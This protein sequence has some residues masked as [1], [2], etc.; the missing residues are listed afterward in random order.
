MPKNNKVDNC[1][2]VTMHGLNKWYQKESEHLGWMILAH[3]KG[4]DDKIT[5]YK[6]SL[7]L[8]KQSLEKKIKDIKDP[9]S[10]HDLELMLH[11]VEVLIKHVN[12]DFSK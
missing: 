2:E 8:L 6:M 5:N 3:D 9:D 1:C 7:K 4:L 11:N 12:K 10:K